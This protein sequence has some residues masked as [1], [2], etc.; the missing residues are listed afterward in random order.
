[1]EKYITIIGSRNITDAEFFTLQKMA[2]S[3]HGMGYTL[4]SGGADGSDS[5]INHLANV[6][7]YIP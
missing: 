7:I 5:S 2:S 1:M 3:L 4:R 6:E